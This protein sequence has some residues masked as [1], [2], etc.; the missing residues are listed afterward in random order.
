M[1]KLRL[2]TGITTLLVF[3]FF[4]NVRAQNF[5]VDDTSINAAMNQV[6]ALLDKSRV[7]TGLLLDYGI[8][9]TNLAA[10][11]GTILVDSTRNT[12][13]TVMS[14]YN[15]L[16]TSIISTNAGSFLHPLYVDSLWQLQRTAEQITLCG[17]YYQYA[18]FDPGAVAG[19]KLTVT[20]NQ[21][22]DVFVGGVWQN[23][24]QV[25]QV[26]CMSPS[27][28]SYN[29]NGSYSFN[30]LLPPGLFLTNSTGAVSSISCDFG[31]G[32]GFRTITPGILTH[33]AYGS[34]GKK[35][36]TFKYNLAAGGSLQSQT[37]ITLDSVA[38]G[39]SVFA[40][41]RHGGG[42]CSAANL[43][44]FKH[45][46]YGFQSAPIPITASASFYGQT[47]NGFMTILYG[48]SDLK[49]HNPLIIAE[50]YDPGDVLKPE[51]RYGISNINGFINQLYDPVTGVPN[52]NLSN[53]I[54]SGNYDIIYVDWAHGSD[55]IERNGKLLESVINYV[56]ANKV[57]TTPN[58]LIGQS[59]GALVSRW[60]LK[61]MEN[62]GVNHQV[63]MFVSWD[64]PHQGANIPIAFQYASRQAL[65]LYVK[66]NIP[67]LFNIYNTFII[68]LAN[69]Y[70][71]TANLI[72][73]LY[74]GSP[75]AYASG[76]NLP[77]LIMSALTLQD[78][79]APREMLI[80][81]IT[82]A[83]NLD[84][85]IH[86]TWQ[87]AYRAM[88]YPTQCVNV[89]VSNGSECGMT[90]LFNPGQSLIDIRGNA[91]PSFFSDFFGLTN[92]ANTF[93]GIALNDPVLIGLGLLPGSSKYSVQF[94]CNAQPNQTTAQQ[95]VG[96]ISYSKNF[97]WGGS[98]THNITNWSFN[99]NPSILPY[100]F[101]PGGR[102]LTGVNLTDIRYSNFLVKFNLSVLADQ[103]S[104][105]FIP[106]PSAL[107]IG[108]G[109]VSLTFADYDRPYSG[110][111]PLTAPKT[112]PFSFWATAIGESPNMN[113]PHIEINQH[114]GNW[115][116]AQLT[117][118]MFTNACIAYC[119]GFHIN[120]PAT[121]CAA[122]QTY[123]INSV[124]GASYSWF[125][126][127]GIQIVSGNGTSTVG[128]TFSNT[129]D[130]QTLF[131]TVRTSTCGTY[132]TSFSIAPGLAPP[133]VTCSQLGNGSCMIVTPRCPT[134]FF[135]PYGFAVPNPNWQ[136][137]TGWQ[138]M[139]SGGVFNDGTTTRNTIFS[140]PSITATATG[141][142]GSMT[143]TVQ[144]INNCGQVTTQ[145]PP[146][147]FVNVS[148]QQACSP[149]GGFKV[150]PNPATTTLSIAPDNELN[151]LAAP[152]GGTKEATTGVQAT[153]NGTGS[154][155]KG[156]GAGGSLKGIG[157]TMIEIFDKT[158][159][160]V[161]HLEFAPGTRN[162]RVDISNLPI[163]IYIVRLF[164]G[165]NWE[166]HVIRKDA[167]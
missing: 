68:P 156:T 159:R 94:T 154:A 93:L 108:S 27:I 31:D 46:M 42:V 146:L 125:G 2:A 8:D 10:Y 57:T 25:K 139:V 36:W 110:S 98:I 53:Q 17:L 30:V 50:G 88:G 162:A 167:N 55:F 9:F 28:N 99:S 34:G 21:V 49:I 128:V 165:T 43:I 97:F 138:W 84:N 26:V 136:G 18:Q 69:N 150:S 142:S 144:P 131:C 152:A 6:F 126:S 52:S 33:L 82:T 35:T 11:N 58:I 77:Q 1:K 103:P 147:I 155:V 61:D 59:M 22:Q 130:Q 64:G 16:A 121:V 73:G 7:P 24:Y 15:T 123:T 87:S 65:S 86:N 47:E 137:I 161:K 149:F 105:C 122:N 37:D 132:T 114:N 116:A 133:S 44:K 70:I 127:A 109:A 23:P 111:I 75:W 153:A 62:S 96:K 141:S 112:S 13:E 67:S 135:Q 164:T 72:R 101:F 80:N 56:N 151:G 115:V 78:Y 145:F 81:Y 143:V 90:Q 14:V 79:P 117:G 51:Q 113:E 166:Q 106:T 74:G 63:R 83:G 158:G 100:D 157:F 119:G 163:D 4:S 107:D 85:S 95:Y 40:H 48:N 148:S 45:M 38:G 124:S 60:A 118:P 120:G 92:F 39:A 12:S 102:Y 3:F 71:L 91:S 54:L 76:T 32:N 29:S 160:R 41:P 19:G 89:A 140:V 104:F 134:G 66:S 129:D 20:N 5:P